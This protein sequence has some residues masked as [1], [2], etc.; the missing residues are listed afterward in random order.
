MMMKTS[1][2]ETEKDIGELWKQELK[3]SILQAEREE[4]QLAKE[5]KSF[6]EDFPAITVIVDGGWSKR[7]HK[8]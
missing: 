4:K 5:K 3:E 1:F 7:A 2:I 8:H 6:H